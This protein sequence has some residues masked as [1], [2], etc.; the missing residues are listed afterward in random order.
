MLHFQN[1]ELKETVGRIEK[2]MKANLQTQVEALSSLNNVCTLLRPELQKTSELAILCIDRVT[3]V[4]EENQN[5]RK[6]K[7]SKE[8]NSR[9]CI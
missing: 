4:T 1:S 7:W 3:T 9:Y 6:V 8:H 2:E 5:L